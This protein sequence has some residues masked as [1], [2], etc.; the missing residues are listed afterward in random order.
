VFTHT[1][2][3]AFAAA[4]SEL[5]AAGPDAAVFELAGFTADDA[6]AEAAGA[7]AGFAA[8]AGVAACALAG[9]AAAAGVAAGA[10]AAGAAAGAAAGVLAAVLA[11][12]FLLFRDFLAVVADVSLLAAVLAAGVLEVCVLAEE[13]VLFFFDFFLVVVSVLC[14]S[15]E[16]ACAAAMTGMNA[17]TN[18]NDNTAIHK[19]TLYR[20][21]IISYFLTS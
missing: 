15:V 6:G 12:A 17:R 10:L 8:A 4:M 18:A 1:L 7:L 13:S 21:F 9:F 19:L 16:L 5:E 20:E 3:L 2:P 14:V 11:S